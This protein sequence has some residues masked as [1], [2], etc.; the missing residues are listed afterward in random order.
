[1]PTKEWILKNKEHLRAYKKTWQASRID[2]KRKSDRERYLRIREEIKRRTANYYAKNR[3]KMIRKGIEYTQRRRKEDLNYLI[4][5]RLRCRV[6]QAVRKQASNKARKTIELLGCSVASFRIYIESKFQPG[7]TWDNIHLDHIVPC[8]L[9]NLTN[10]AHQKICF[11][12][13]NY[14]PLFAPDN[15]AKGAQLLHPVQIGLPL[16]E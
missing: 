13:S 4:T 5:C 14:Q 1:M 11:H 10:P 2:Q 15:E 16:P 9:F 7:M 6:K 12:F 3:E 8:A